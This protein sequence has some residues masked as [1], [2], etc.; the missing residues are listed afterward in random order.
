MFALALSLGALAGLAVGQ[1][2]PPTKGVTVLKSKIH[3]NV[4]ISYKEVRSL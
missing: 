2:P 4:T 1:F 3:E